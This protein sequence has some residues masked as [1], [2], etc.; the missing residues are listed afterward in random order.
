MWH[1][2]IHAHEH[3][4]VQTLLLECNLKCVS[5]SVNLKRWNMTFMSKE[6]TTRRVDEESATQH[7]RWHRNSCTRTVI[8]I[9][10]C[11]EMQCSEAIYTYWNVARNPD[12]FAVHYLQTHFYYMWYVYVFV[13]NFHSKQTLHHQN[14]FEVKFNHWNRFE[15]TYSN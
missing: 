13:F 14:T 4:H 15:S 10:L 3:F 7:H 12:F 2:F 5:A 8:S 9:R 11:N 1:T 6:N